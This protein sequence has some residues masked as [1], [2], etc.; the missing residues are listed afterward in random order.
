MQ[1]IVRVSFISIYTFLIKLLTLEPLF[2]DNFLNDGS[3]STYS[4][5]KKYL[6]IVKFRGS[7][8]GKVSKSISLH[9]NNS[10]RF[11]RA[12]IGNAIKIKASLIARRAA[13]PP[14]IIIPKLSRESH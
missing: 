4:F 13:E 11:K 2:V 8:I 9:V 10:I 7:N 5:H 14:I 3:N 12:A 1:E 6:Y